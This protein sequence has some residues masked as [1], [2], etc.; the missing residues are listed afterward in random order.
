MN[1]MP[2]ADLSTIEEGLHT[3]AEALIEAY[4]EAARPPDLPVATPDILVQ[5]ML[6]LLSVLRLQGAPDLQLDNLETRDINALGNY[7]IRL[8]ADLT[9]W[10][11]ALRLPEASNGLREL[12]Y[13]FALWA[14]RKDA[15]I[16]DLQP[17]VDAL[18]F[19]ANRIKEPYVLEDLYQAAADLQNAV[20]PSLSQDLD[21]S[22]PGRPWRLL[23]LNR[24]IIATRSHQPMLMEAAFKNL[25]ELLPEDAEN[26]FREGMEQM[27]ALDYPGKVRVV[28]EKYYQ[29]WCAPKH[30]H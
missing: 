9:A 15:E 28:M 18:A 14:A 21:R 22:N 5:S 10:A 6:R 27:D 7:G 23:V 30:L 12:T 4:E 26:F 13:A 17:V 1:T 3:F 8:L 20:D 2:A 11:S 29:L 24:A 19:V 16:T 25:T